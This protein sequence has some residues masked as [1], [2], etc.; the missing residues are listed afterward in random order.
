MIRNEHSTQPQSA[1]DNLQQW[2]VAH[3]CEQNDQRDAASSVAGDEK[4][5]FALHQDVKS[6]ELGPR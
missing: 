1:Y 6:F 4:S 3:K 2:S 5:A